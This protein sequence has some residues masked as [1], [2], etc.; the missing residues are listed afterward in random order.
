[1][2]WKS[3]L[4]IGMLGS[5]IGV[6]AEAGL[7]VE[8]RREAALMRKEGNWKD[9]L[10]VYQR[11]L[12]EV[13]DAGSAEDLE[14][15]VESLGRLNRVEEW[16]GLVEGAVEG[17]GENRGLLARAGV[18]YVGAQ[19]W[20][21]MLDGE[22]KRGHHRGGGQWVNSTERD[23]VRAMQLL[24]KALKQENGAVPGGELEGVMGR[25]AQAVTMGR[26]GRNQ[27]WALGVLTPLDVL[28]DYGDGSELSSGSG[29][30]VDEE[31]N[32]LFMKVPESW[33]TAA[34]DGERWRWLL[35][36]RS[37][38]NPKVAGA[39]QM[40]WV[41]FLVSSYG[42]RTMAG[43]GWWRQSGPDESKG[44]LQVHTL[45]DDESVASLA[46][47]VKRFALEE[48]YQ[49]IPALRRI[50]TDKKNSAAEEAGDLLV[51]ILLDRR[52]YD[53][54]VT[55]LDAV[56]ARFG[57]GNKNRRAKLMAQITG[58]WGRFEPVQM[59]GA[60]AKPSV[61]F[62]Y[63]N[64]KVATLSLHRIKLDLLVGDIMEYLEGNPR[65][66]DWE[67]LN[68]GAIG[69]RLV[70]GDAQKYK[71]EK[72][73]SWKEDLQPRAKHWDTR[74]HIEVPS[75]EAGAYLL[76]AKAGDG[77]TSWIVVWISDTA[78]VR[79]QLEDGLLYFLGDAE[80]AAPLEGT[81]EFF[82]YRVEHRKGVKGA[83][84]KFDVHTKRLTRKTGADGTARLGKDVLDHRYQWM[85]V[86]R[87]KGER[88]A[89]MGFQHQRWRDYRWDTYRTDKSYGV[90]DRP[91]YRP[92]QMVHLKFW[93]RSARY[94][95]GDES[96]Y[97]G[98]NCHVEIHHAGSGKL[99]T[100]KDLRTDEFG[101]VELDYELPE[102]ARLGQYT[103]LIDG[104][105]PPGNLKFRVEE[106]KKPEYEVKVDGPDAPVRLGETIEAKVLA[107]YY[108]GAPVTKARVKVKVQRYSHT[109]R[110]FPQG[111]WD[112]LFGEGYWWFGPDYGWYPGWKH[113][114][115]IAP[116]P[117][118]WHRQR[119][120]PPEL[121][122]EREYAIGP[123]GMVAVK[124]DTSV[125]KLVHGDMDHRYEITAEVIDASRRTI[126]GKGSVLAARKP[127]EV[128]TWLDRGYARPGEPVTVSFAAKTLD[129]RAVKATGSATLYRVR[130]DGDGTITEKMVKTW[131]QQ[132]DESGEGEFVI[133]APERGQYRMAVAMTDGKGNKAEGATVFVVRGE[134]DD[135]QG[136]R[137]NDLELVLDRK[138][139]APGQE[140][141]ILVN[142]NEPDA[143]VLMFLRSN[144]GVAENLEL[145][146]IDGKS[147]EFTLPLEKRDMPNM[148][149]E[150]VTV[151][152]GQVVTVA[153]QI[154]LP[155]VKRVLTV[156]VLPEKTKLKPREKSAIRI[157]LTDEQGEPF[158]GTSAVTIYD[159]SLEYISGGSNVPEIRK[160]FWDWK[161]RFSRGGLSHSQQQGSANLA[162]RKAERMGTLGV[163]GA[164]LADMEG[165][166][167]SGGASYGARL[168]R[169]TLSKSAA[170]PMSAALAMDSASDGEMPMKDSGGKGGGGEAVPE[171]MVRSEFADLVKWVGAV[172]TDA[173]GEAVIEVE[174]P[175]NL[176]T[177]KVKT[178]AVG[179]GTRVG[180]GSAEIITSKDLIIRLQAPRF[181][182]E[183][184]R[185]TL[186]AVVHNYH[187]E[188][189]EV[190]VSLELDGGT[191]VAMSEAAST[192]VIPPGGEKRIN[193]TTVAKQ[194]GEVTVRMK[195]IAR[196]DADAMEMTFPVYVH[197]MART[198]SWSRGIG[199]KGKKAVI[200]FEVPEKRRPNETR[201]EIRYSPSVAGAMVDA[202]PYLANY[203]YG[204]TEQT[205]NRF[206][207]TVVTQKLLQE[208]KVDLAAVKNKRVNLNP[209]EI[210][211]A[212]ERA[213]QWKHWKE[214]PVWDKD[215]VD[216]MVRTGVA[217]LREM[218]V[219]D[220][221]W[222]WFSAWGEHSYPHTTAV[223]VHGLQVA[224]ANG[225]KVPDKMLKRG[226][227]WLQKHEEKE[228]GRIRMWNKRKKNTKKRADAMDA[229][230]RRVLGEA[231]VDHKEMLGFLFRDKVELPVYA[232]CLLGLELHRVK[233]NKDRD[234]VIH[235]IE[236]F[237]ETD[238]E[239]QTAWLNLGN[240]GYWW[241]WYGSEFEAH[242][243]Y[244]KLL[245]AVKPK[246]PE[247]RG[248]VKYLINNRKHATYWN[249]TRDT[250][251]CIEAIADY[252]RE[253]GED[254]PDME[255]EVILDEKVLKTVTITRENLFSFDG[256]AVV[257]GD[258]LAAGTH[259]IELRKKGRGSLY[260]NA[261][262]TVFTLEDF[263]RKTGLEVKVERSFYKLIPVEASQAVA[264]S[265]G[266]ALSQ[267]I[268]KYERLALKSGDT[269]TSGDL[270]E[271]ELSIDSKNDY[272]YLVFEDWKAA[273]L[274]P[275]EVRSGHNAKGL[276]AFMELRDEKVAL[277]VRSLPRGRHNLSYRL[278][279]EIPG[280]FSALPT[281]AEG[282][283]APELRA[284]SNEMKIEVRD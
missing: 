133:E 255:V 74:T 166:M 62:V 171:V 136:M 236:Q 190:A 43:Y 267:R 117:V 222:G 71:G 164:Q 139:Y 183:N 215:E 57:K 122:M 111:R 177:W 169:A 188:A 79:H 39:V 130:V 224:K 168:G 106:Y 279:A 228:A 246:S 198:E 155:P 217:R 128:T 4:L 268:E 11:L 181:F 21:Y 179:H 94:D 253:S 84:R 2:N 26:M 197:G 167:A 65:K 124:I 275:V 7:P 112:W 243:W 95:L 46:G 89:L 263:I 69:G 206:V 282:M 154:V 203:P 273:G 265:K 180:E 223:V 75:D 250:A 234:A 141:K 156:E 262:L 158:A 52:Q 252:L 176:T 194:E 178:W 115:C 119:W 31:G 184:D 163:F 51:A 66:L 170:V 45:K 47:G 1:M 216:K 19:H 87:A 86:G 36:E 157:R 271:V 22:Y 242:A 235:N 101:G 96:V 131:D 85:A 126:V 259:V 173:R 257:A 125:A 277:F 151:A 114:G 274:E 281:T 42:V 140:A 218:Q 5:G 108:H 284:N 278:R 100:V 23:R 161:R 48:D 50:Y 192:V 244:L 249:S 247:A 109:T 208:M 33:E 212:G 210:G 261:Y 63:R 82:G 207:P 78:M 53:R 123:D 254:S 270:I 248:L 56:M 237:L 40:E 146:K 144:G 272:S 90:T 60:G 104:A 266:Q 160:F 269:V 72:V 231:E 55:E 13:D 77:N 121:V 211:E 12:E 202:L 209:Q 70:E 20:G 18:L 182:V 88:M 73:S 28:P 162:R 127:F 172:E 264:G 129:G 81:I 10:G 187:K 61:P 64:A 241:W 54:A 41:R 49:F 238:R 110:W 213:A 280:S 9:A 138:E 189:K 230:V 16:D 113:W 201:L 226:V 93:S 92:G 58:D 256:T 83:L 204:C 200:E 97:A 34:N 67:K 132:L 14:R 258:I 221:G 91:V 120:T 193:W 220:G 153:K 6:G 17:H 225:A 149:V 240:S 175:D 3:V 227:A 239:N 29:A 38:L 80:N 159:K 15:A 219:G 150:A 191:L 35:T 8:L 229:L 102:D 233:R 148:Y 195:A 186:S 99:H 44:I 135:G 107:T 25:L 30:P 152:R 199:P 105:I 137:F 118:W 116:V 147:R 251:Y 145:L 103:V 260:A 98:K 245:A 174:M 165:G 142:A 214:N 185:V 24:R 27:V 143:T 276:G 205:L 283:Y 196:D 76:E 32:P 59:F 134:K 37:R 232:K 68:V